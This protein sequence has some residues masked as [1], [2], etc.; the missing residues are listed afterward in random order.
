MYENT[1]KMISK[2]LILF[3]LCIH[4]YKVKYILSINSSLWFT[5]R[6]VTTRIECIRHGY[7][8]ENLMS[9]V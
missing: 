7:S 8:A 5:I 1:K 4:I 9:T 6:K 2:M 3:I